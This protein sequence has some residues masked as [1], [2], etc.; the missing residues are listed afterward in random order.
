[1]N[2]PADISTLTVTFQSQ[3]HPFTTYPGQNI[4]R[5]GNTVF[6]TVTVPDGAFNIIVGPS[7]DYIQH[8]GFSTTL[9]GGNTVIQDHPAVQKR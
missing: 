6:Y 9:T 5:S 7:T 8:S 2:S 1:M 3:V 4:N